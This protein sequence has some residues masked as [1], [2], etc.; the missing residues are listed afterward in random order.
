MGDSSNLVLRTIYI[1]DLVDRALTAHSQSTGISKAELFR[2]WLAIGV[3]A[4]R[5]GRRSRVPSPVSDS[6][7]TL[8]TV[9]LSPIMDHFLR[10]QAFD[11]HL[12][13]N[14]VMRQYLRIGFEL[15]S[16]GDQPSATP[17]PGRN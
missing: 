16:L 8:K 6:P 5:Q 17:I 10:V 13:K 9:G 2:R 14:E 4:V 7:L 3:R 11:E 12:P 15:S 1:D